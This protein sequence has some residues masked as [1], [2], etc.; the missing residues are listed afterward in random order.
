MNA[1]DFLILAFVLLAALNGFR[2]GAGLQLTTYAGL[3]LGLLVGALLAPQ[4]AQLASTSFSQAAVALTALL[5]FALLGDAAGWVIGLKVWT[6]ARRSPLGVVDSVAGSVVAVVA[7]LLFTWFVGFNLA[8]GPFPGVSNEVRGSAIVRGLDR[9]LPRPPALFAEVRQF[10]NRFGFPEVFAD[11]PPAPAGPVQGPTKGQVAEVARRVE[12]SM[13][14]IVGQACGAIQEGSG[15]FVAPNYVIT[16][17]HVVAGV[18][19]PQVQRQNG[20][21]QAATTVLFNP[22]I[23]VAVLRVSSTGKPLSLDPQDVARGTKGAVLGYPGGGPLRAGQAAVRRDLNAIGRDIYGRSVVQRDVYELQ[24]IVRPGNS[25]GAFMLLDGQ[26]GGLVFAASTTDPKVGYAL[27]SKQVL[28]LV[29]AA[30]KRTQPVS[31]QDCAR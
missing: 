13:A 10:L 5:A 3:L 20:G 15:F 21:T 23:D 16:N 18:R 11:I 26:V 4:L 31:T 17:A 29:T 2:R 8:N 9:T 6:L 28:P 19:S 22:R 14:R 1:L 12:N 25:G 7:V 27:T 30:E 24:A